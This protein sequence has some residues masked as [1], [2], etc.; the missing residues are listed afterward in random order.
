MGRPR[1]AAR[2]GGAGAAGRCITL[3]QADSPLPTA[4]WLLPVG[5]VLG[6]SISTAA[7]FDSRAA[8]LPILLLIGAIGAACWWCRG[9][10]PPRWWAADLAGAGVAK[11]KGASSGLN[12]PRFAWGAG[13]HHRLQDR[14]CIAASGPELSGRFSNCQPQSGHGWRHPT[15]EPDQVE[16]WLRA[17]AGADMPS[18]PVAAARTMRPVGQSCTPSDGNPTQA[19][20]KRRRRR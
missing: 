17:L 1:S 11:A 6:L 12:Q 3:A 8:A 13:A 9:W 2:D 4:H 10:P 14:A 5:L 18:L 20:E 15:T 7:F 16:P 19:S